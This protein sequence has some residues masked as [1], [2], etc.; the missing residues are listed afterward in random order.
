MHNSKALF[1]EFLDQISS[2]ENKEETRSMAFMVFENLLG[3]SKTDVLANRAIEVTSKQSQSLV[4]ISQRIKQQEPIQYILGEADFLGRKFI[5][6][7][8]VLIPRPETEELVVLITNDLRSK[9]LNRQFRILDIGTGSGCIPITLALELSAE[10]FAYDISEAAL[11]LAHRNAKSLKANVS[12]SKH[13]ILKE[14][15]KQ[16]DLDVIVSNPPYITL[17]EKSAMMKNVV[18][19]EPHLA[20]FVPDDDP[21][22]FY[23]VIA[24]KSKKALKSQGYLYVEINEQYAKHVADLFASFGYQDIS[25]FKDLSGKNRIV[26]CIQE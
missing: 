9:K 14:E 24:A 11:D 23:K 26:R 8:S 16:H 12:F 3:L 17:R 4:D 5:V 1:Q 7:G 2:K 22:L 25:I 6:D 20:L 18:G 13:D 21:L 10:V 19:Y 15:I